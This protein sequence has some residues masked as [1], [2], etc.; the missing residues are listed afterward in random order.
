M[1]KK[2]II[3]GF[4][5]FGGAEAISKLDDADWYGIGK[6]SPRVDYNRNELELF[7]FSKNLP[8][9]IKKIQLPASLLGKFNQNMSVYFDQLSRTRSCRTG[10]PEQNRQ[11][12]LL[13]LKWWYDKYQDVDIEWAFF[14][15]PPHLGV[16]RVLSDYLEWKGVMVRWGMQTL[17]PPLYMVTD[18][19]LNV[20]PA[21]SLLKNI[22]KQ[23]MPHCEKEI[24]FY[25]KTL[26]LKKPS[27]L[28]WLE[29][30]TKAG[31]G[32]SRY[33][34][35]WADMAYFDGKKYFKRIEDK[36]NK[37]KYKFDKIVKDDIPFVYFPLHYQPEMTTS[38]LGGVFS[39]QV[40][41]IE[42]LHEK[43]PIGWKI[44]VKENPIQTFQYRDDRFFKRLKMLQN[45]VFSSTSVD[46]KWLISKSQITA[47]I[48][49]TALWEAVRM[50]KPTLMFGRAW[51]EGF[52]GITPYHPNLKLDELASA[53]ISINQLEQDFQIFI[54]KC[55]RGVIDADYNESSGVDL[56][57]NISLI[58][59]LFV[60]LTQQ[61][62]KLSC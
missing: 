20:I 10:T 9:S 60:D 31:L 11:H 14:A 36:I 43:L 59:R 56:K 2:K 6:Y 45:V 61:R 38:A 13:L 57:E 30:R 17:F 18:T 7:S 49:G 39:D 44:V 35:Q 12:I 19:D 27:F 15:M 51:Y 5:G 50:Q 29:S 21:P 1:N 42:V 52:E 16:D 28:K 32:D 33:S 47:T 22:G 54:E 26:R 34:V 8:D 46:S 23:E 48:T 53:T 3:Y 62:M 55:Y 24:L 25:M 4:E 40:L 58:T 41:A 37:D